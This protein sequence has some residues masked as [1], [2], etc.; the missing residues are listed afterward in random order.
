MGSQGLAVVR[1]IWP[2]ICREHGG[3]WVAL[4]NVRY[5][6]STAQ[7]IEA[8][9]VDTDEDLAELCARMR[10][11]DRSSCAILM[12]EDDTYLAPSVHRPSQTPPPRAVQH[13]SGSA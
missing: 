6:P 10:A 13:L 9:V 8:D 2:D 12:C 4:D 5:D 7:P 11:S 3:R 1:M